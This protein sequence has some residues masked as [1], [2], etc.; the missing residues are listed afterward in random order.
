[1]MTTPLQT[2]WRESKMEI[3]ARFLS[4][5]IRVPRGRREGKIF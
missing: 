2:L 4:S 3:S 1:M 5:E